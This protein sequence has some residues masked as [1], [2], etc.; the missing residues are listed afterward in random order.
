VGQERASEAAAVINPVGIRAKKVLLW[1]ANLKLK[2]ELAYYALG[3]RLTKGMII[4]SN[5]MPPCWK[6]SL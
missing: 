3:L 2:G 4:S 6:V 5:E 1:I